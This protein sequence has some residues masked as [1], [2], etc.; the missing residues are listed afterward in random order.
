M[1]QQRMNGAGG[2]GVCEIMIAC[3]YCYI[4]V[5]HLRLIAGLRGEGMNIENRGWDQEDALAGDIPA[6][7][8]RG[9]RRLIWIAGA[10]ILILALITFV[11]MRHG[12]SDAKTTTTVPT[13]TVFVP[14]RVPVA[15][16]ITATGT[17]SAKREMPVGVAGDGGMVSRV[18]VD[19]G[20]WVQA[21]QTLATV[22]PAVRAAMA[23]QSQA[24]I[25]S[26]VANAKLAQSQLDRAQALVARGFISKADIDSRT[27]TRDAANAAVSLA[28]AQYR[29][30]MAQLGRLDIRAPAAGLVLSRD[31]EAGQI[32][33]SGSPP[34][35]K[36]A[37]DG[38]F[39][40]RARLAEQD[41]AG[42]R[43]GMPVRV[44][45]IGATQSFTG[46]VWQ[47]SPVIDPTTRQGEARV[48]LAYAPALRPGG[49]ASARFDSADITAP[50]LPESAV[51]SDA[52]GNYV[53]IVDA[54][55]HVARRDVKIGNVSDAGIAISAGLSGSEQV[56]YS[57]GAFLNPGDKVIP[58]LRKA[59]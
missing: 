7:T 59:G 16:T 40:L 27:A 13:V 11:V 1:P 12:S 42:V 8:R 48:Q 35:F 54:S 25:A 6:D 44:T 55:G 58:D 36:I 28:Q 33:S 9:R 45:P 5:T 31:V 39:E 26:A 49:F 29:E 43:V 18:L 37:M 41:L 53:Y 2:G 17:L 30:N 46:S 15:A 20:S 19:A 32:V 24:Q 14:G 47:V 34:L 50:L 52:K 22:D 10:A 51:L 57:A 21:G 4:T 3:R 23:A 38:E 56:V